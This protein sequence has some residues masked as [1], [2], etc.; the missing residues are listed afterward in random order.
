MREKG[1]VILIGILVG[2]FISGQVV[3]ASQSKGIPSVVATYKR[4]ISVSNVGINVSNSNVSSVSTNVNN[5]NV[6]NIKKI[7]GWIRKLSLLGILAGIVHITGLYKMIVERKFN[8]DSISVE[9]LTEPPVNCEKYAIFNCGKISKGDLT[10][11]QGEESHYRY[12]ITIIIKSM[13]SRKK[14]ENLAIKEIVVRMDDYFVEYIPQGKTIFKCGIC[15]VALGVE[16]RCSILMQVPTAKRQTD[17][18][19]LNEARLSFFE[20]PEK[21]L[22]Y[23]LFFVNAKKTS[24]FSF[25]FSKPRIVWFREKVYS[26]DGFNVGIESDEIKKGKLSDLKKEN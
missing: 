17:Q 21:F 15:G 18:E 11:E 2:L 4:N 5:S 12:K 26:S 3:F 7:W 6:S 16:E 14:I 13:P 22:M 24:F 25:I 23:I 20:N 1:R 19:S 8:I 10:I 9:L